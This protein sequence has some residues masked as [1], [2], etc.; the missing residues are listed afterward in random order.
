M[1]L[2]SISV[3]SHRRRFTS[4]PF[5]NKRTTVCT[6]VMAA[7][8][9]ARARWTQAETF[10]LIRLWEDKLQDLRK[11]KRNARVYAAIVDELR[12][13]GIAKT[14]KETKTKIENLGNKYRQ[15]WLLFFFFGAVHIREVKEIRGLYCT[16]YRCKVFS[17]MDACE[18]VFSKRTNAG[19][20]L[21]LLCALTSQI[22]HGH[23]CH[24]VL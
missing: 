10:T 8:A 21:G 6:C 19:R 17:S 12:E 7:A 14:L 5:V 16:Q 3:A 23:L 1:F 24:F 13:L 22:V 4:R 11:A 15:V 18:I 20:S 2:L 9:A